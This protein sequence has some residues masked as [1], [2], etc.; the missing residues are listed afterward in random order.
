MP[1]SW[2]KCCLK[3]VLRKQSLLASVFENV[4]IILNCISLLKPRWESEDEGGDCSEFLSSTNTLFQTVFWAVAEWRLTSPRQKMCWCYP[5]RSRW[6]HNT[7][8]QL[9]DDGQWIMNFRMTRQTLFEIADVLRPYRMRRDTVMRS[10]VPV[11]ERVA[12]GVY[13]LASRSCY[14]TIAHVFQKSTSTIASVVVEV[15]LAIEHTLLKQE[16]RVM[17]FSKL[18]IRHSKPTPEP[19][20]WNYPVRTMPHYFSFLFQML[21]STGKH[22]FPH[23]IRAVDS[24][25]VPITPPKK[26]VLAYF[27]RKSFHSILLQAA[28]DGDGTMMH[29]CSDPHYCSRKWRRAH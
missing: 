18:R 8:L 5:G 1:A 3:S 12:I 22:G 28:C 27:N 19:H 21:S 7:I 11:E 14:R 10:A 2:K 17:D 13:Y 15:C 9:W 25:H 6:F 24:C 29:M 23:C 16:V 4:S 20:P 26:E